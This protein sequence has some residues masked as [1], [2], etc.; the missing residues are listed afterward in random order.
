[1]HLVIPRHTNTFGTHTGSDPRPPK[2][3]QL[4][5]PV[6]LLPLRRLEP[7]LAR[8]DIHDHD[9]VPIL[10]IRQ[11]LPP[12]D[13]GR[14]LDPM[15]Q[16]QERS[17]HAPENMPAQALGQTLPVEILRGELMPRQGVGPR[18]V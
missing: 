4:A 13:A 18:R 14:L 15:M 9:G 7:D 2:A 11:H 12:H 1:M 3:A 16:P 6:R 10:I 17:T 5:L 8:A